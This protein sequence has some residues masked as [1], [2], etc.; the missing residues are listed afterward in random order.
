MKVLVFVAVILL[1]TNN[2]A[3]GDAEQS[4]SELL[5]NAIESYNAAFDTT[6]RKLRLRRFR[7]AEIL[8]EQVI[9]EQAIKN[10]NLFVNLGNAS[11][12]AERVGPAIVAYRRALQVDPNHRQAQQ[13]LRYARSLLPQWVP[14]PEASLGSFNSLLGSIINGT[15][16]EM[17]RHASILFLV[18]AIFLAWSIRSGRSIA[19]NFG[20]VFSIGWIAFLAF[21]FVRSGQSNP[22]VAVL[23]LPE[24]IARSADS[25]NAPPRF[26]EPLPDG[27]EVQI[28]EDRRDWLRVRIEDG[29]DGWLPASSVVSIDETGSKGVSD[30][31]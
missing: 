10:A 27:T 16:D 13:N 12:G 7:E 19:R 1:A 18:A 26:A 24:T 14:R 9:T 25:I 23:V 21:S 20:I 5:S 8:F 3:A 2:V 17:Q 30:G 22:R 31:I 29:R 28:V 15:P 4:P 6:N 11:I